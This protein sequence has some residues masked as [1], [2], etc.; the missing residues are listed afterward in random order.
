MPGSY[1]IDVPRRIVFSRGWGVLLDADI[2][3]HAD[4]L[5]ADRRFDPAFRQITDFLEVS[6]IRLTSASIQHVAAHNPFRPDARRGFAVALDRGFELLHMYGLYTVADAN[7]F[8]I[9]RA[10]GPAMEWIGLDAETPWPSPP[11]A[12]FGVK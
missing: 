2:A 4:A 5:R 12:L 7:Q 1:L 11:D 3:S 9:F 8:G 10:L 6:E